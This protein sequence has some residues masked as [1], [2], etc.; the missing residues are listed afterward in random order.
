MLA[1]GRDGILKRDEIETVANYVLS[2][3]GKAFDLKLSLA[4]RAA[5]SSPRT[6]PPATATPAKA[7]ASWAPPT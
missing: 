2:L 5:R 1:F 7:T 6:A 3:S 4:R